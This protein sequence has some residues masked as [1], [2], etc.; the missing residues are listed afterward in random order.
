LAYNL[1]IEQQ[2][3]NIFSEKLFYGKLFDVSNFLNSLFLMFYK[4]L[5]KTFFLMLKKNCK[6]DLFYNI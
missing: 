6:K 4:I 2:K 1:I 5:R 3:Q